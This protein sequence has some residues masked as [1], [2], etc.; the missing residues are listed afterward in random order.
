MANDLP[1]TTWDVAAMLGA[2]CDHETLGRLLNYLL[3]CDAEPLLND[4]QVEVGEAIFNALS[5][6]RPDAVSFAMSGKV[7]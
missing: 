1:T 4:K 2:A 6:L 5:E 7:R 3:C